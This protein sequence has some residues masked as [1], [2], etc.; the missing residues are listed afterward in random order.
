M[1]RVHRLGQA[2]PVKITRLIA[3][4]TVEERME[5]LQQ[6][7]QNVYRAAMSKLSKEELQQLRIS[8]VR[9]IFQ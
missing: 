1:D 8:Q 5:D 2:K 9:K 4:E 3:S 6:V 7:K